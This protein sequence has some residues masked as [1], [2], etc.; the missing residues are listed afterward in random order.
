M[1]LLVWIPFTNGL[2]NQGV[3]DATFSYVNNNGKLSS[4]TDGKIGNCY[5]RTASGYADCIRSSKNFNLDGDITMMLWAMVTSTPGDSA[6]GL[7]TNHNHATNSGVGITVKQV[8]TTDYRISCNTGTGSSRTYYTY[9]GT[10]NIKDTW[11]H[12][13]LTY[14]KSRKQL[15]LYVDGNIEYI[16]NNYTNGSAD[17]PFDIFNWS[18]GNY[19]SGNYRPIC[20]INDVRLYD[21]ELSIKEI[22]NIAKGLFIH[23]PLNDLIGNEN[24]VK[25]STQGAGLSQ[26]TYN[27]QDYNFSKAL[28]AGTTYTI[29]CKINMSNEKKAFAVYH[30]GGSIMCGPWIANAGNG[31]YKWSFEATSAMA[32]QTTG[33][34]YGYARVY[35][36]NNTGPQGSTALSGTANVEWIK[37][38]EGSI[39]TGFIPNSTDT[40]YSV[41]GLN[42]ATIRDVSGYNNNGTMSATKPTVFTDSSRCIASMTFANSVY[43]SI[44]IPSITGFANSYTFSWWG[45]TSAYEGKMYWGFS[46]GNR[47]NLYGTGG[48]YCWNTGDG[49]NN[50]FTGVTF[51]SEA[52]NNWHHFAVTGDGTTTKLYIDGV[53]K[54]NATTYK[55]ITGTTIIINGWDTGNSYNFNGQLSDFRLYATALSADDILDLYNKPVSIDNTGKIHAIEYS[56]V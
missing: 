44:P 45:K 6:N 1:S 21:H 10:T 41:L 52:D 9:Y 4:A 19:T 11:H 16:L 29:T 38:E 50:K 8:S 39:S 48:V 56:E 49:A 14:S 12:L 51:A 53:F 17:N 36:S 27:L 30:S 47:L 55:A 13:A 7:I 35:V 3:S 5:Q 24:L 23:L 33:G 26:T 31:I 18:T 40:L 32:S 34:G 15:L 42:L 25:N 43:I 46:N 20:K 37:I 28:V 2:T 54:A 22:K